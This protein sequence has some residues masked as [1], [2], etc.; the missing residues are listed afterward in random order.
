MGCDLKGPT[1]RL[2]LVP[3]SPSPVLSIYVKHSILKVLLCDTGSLRCAEYGQG[4]EC[5]ADV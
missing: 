5:A 1:T 4:H 2:F 3:L